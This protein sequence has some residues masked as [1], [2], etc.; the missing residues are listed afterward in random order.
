MQCSLLY[1]ENSEVRHY[2]AT[3]LVNTRYSEISLS[4]IEY[5]RAQLVQVHFLSFC[6]R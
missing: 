1:K 3:M 6:A 5:L 2:E 4:Q